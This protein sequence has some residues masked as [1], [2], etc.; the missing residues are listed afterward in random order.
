MPDPE[1]SKIAEDAA[2]LFLR[3]KDDPK[4]ASLIAERDAFL[5]QGAKHQKAYDA[6][7]RAWTGVKPAKPKRTAPMIVLAIG[8]GYVAYSAADPVTTFLLAD[9]KTQRAP[10][11]IVFPAGDRI[12][13]DAATALQNRSNETERHFAVLDGAALFTVAPEERPFLVEL[14]DVSVRVTGTVFETSHQGEHL[15]VSVIEGSVE[16][17]L[18][19]QNWQ[20]SDGMGFEWSPDS[21]AKIESLPAESIA[22]WRQ[23]RLVANGMRFEEVAAVIDRRLSGTVFIPSASLGQQPVSGVIDLSDPLL[24]LRTLAVSRGARVTRLGPFGAIIRP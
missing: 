20:L 24:A 22:S 21:G 14:G 5:A 7:R 1:P 9:Y 19:D 17:Q 13:L 16:V 4:N 18:G 23:D 10:D 15:A 11:A 8:L 3:L 12:D 6:V 2:D